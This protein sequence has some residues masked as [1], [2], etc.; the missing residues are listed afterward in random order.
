MF[1]YKYSSSSPL[2]MGWS[3]LPEYF[4]YCKKRSE[5]YGKTSIIKVHKFKL[6]KHDLTG[7]E[8]VHKLF[9]SSK[10]QANQSIITVPVTLTITYR[11]SS[12]SQ[13]YFVL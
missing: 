5:I 7:A 13:L 11:L 4:L 1:S 6:H 10:I 8:P 12:L 9:S 3:F 2:K